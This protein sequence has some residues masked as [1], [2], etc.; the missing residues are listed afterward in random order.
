SARRRRR[1]WRAAAGLRPAVDHGP[2]VVSPALA[3][4]ERTRMFAHR[5][6]SRRRLVGGLAAAGGAVLL[7]ACG[8]PTRPTEL[9]KPAAPAPAPTTA[10]AAATSA[11]AAAPAAPTTAAA[12]GAAA[13]SA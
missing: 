10:P 8:T 2:R 11:P 12:A 1:R 13:T 9:P 4:K 5:S 6:L 3:K 7:A